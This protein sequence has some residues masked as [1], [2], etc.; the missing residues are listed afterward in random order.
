MAQSVPKVR[1]ISGCAKLLVVWSARSGGVASAL[2]VRSADVMLMADAA[3]VDQA[4]DY[5]GL[6]PLRRQTEGHGMKLAVVN[7]DSSGVA[8]VGIGTTRRRLT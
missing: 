8:A 1:R 3:N 5:A 6:A 7:A 2:R 4:G